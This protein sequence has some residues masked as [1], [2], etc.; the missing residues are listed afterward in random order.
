MPLET[1]NPWYEI[2][3]KKVFPWSK[4]ALGLELV[5]TYSLL[6]YFTV[7]LWDTRHF[8]SLP[9]IKCNTELFSLLLLSIL[10][11]YWNVYFSF[12]QSIQLRLFAYK[13]MDICFEISQHILVFR[14]NLQYCQMN[15]NSI[16]LEKYV[17]RGVTKHFL[18]LP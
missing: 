9:F 16:N 6:K 17:Y 18:L 15:F 7:F 13:V 8:A 1:W 2:I 12:I 10:R 4:C 11:V 14:L 3:Q 5:R